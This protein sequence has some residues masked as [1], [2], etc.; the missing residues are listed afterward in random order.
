LKNYLNHKHLEVDSIFA[1]NYLRKAK[2]R[3]LDTET[4]LFS[5]NHQHLMKLKIRER[6]LLIYGPLKTKKCAIFTLAHLV[7][8]KTDMT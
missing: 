2:I 4:I 8:L 3:T 1:I 7:Y 6:G 5:Y